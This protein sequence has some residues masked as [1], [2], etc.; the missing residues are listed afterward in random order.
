[1]F[2]C[3]PAIQASMPSK[4]ICL[5]AVAIAIRPEEHWRSMV[6]AGTATGRPRACTR[7][8][9]RFPPPRGSGVEHRSDHR[10]FEYAPF[11]TGAPNGVL[12]GMSHQGRRFGVVESTSERPADRR[13]SGRDN[14][15]FA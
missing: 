7:L 3:P 12:N 8:R 13:A 4:V 10:V 5:A 14:D 2:S 1:M 6:C 15:G 11:E 9:A